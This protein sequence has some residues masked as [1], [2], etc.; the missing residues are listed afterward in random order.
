MSFS[1]CIAREI[2]RYPPPWLSTSAGMG[3]TTIGEI[4]VGGRQRLGDA[5]LILQPNVAAPELRKTLSE[6][7][8]RITEERIAPDGRRHYVVIKAVPGESEYDLRQLTVGPILLEKMPAELLPYAQFRL[9]VAQKALKGALA[10][11]DE[12]Q[13]I[14]LEGEIGI[15]KEVCECLQQ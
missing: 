9:N 6:N 10:G 5:C 1:A 11:G 14:A 4:I 2:L 15:W 3:G 12:E 7:G 13:K 8:Y